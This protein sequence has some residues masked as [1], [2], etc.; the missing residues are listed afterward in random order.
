LFTFCH[1]ALA[2]PY[3][4]PFDTL[5]TPDCVMLGSLRGLYLS[6]G[7][8]Y[9]NDTGKYFDENG[10][11]AYWSQYRWRYYLVPIEMGYKT[12]FG[13][14]FGTQI[15]VVD[16]RTD[17]GWNSGLGDVW[18][19]T[20]YSFKPNEWLRV[21]GRLA[22][23]F[24]SSH[25]GE[26]PA[27]TDPASAFDLC[28]T[29]DTEPTDFLIVE[30][31]LGYRFVGRTDAGYDQYWTTTGGSFYYMSAY[32]GFP[33]S[34]RKII[35]TVPFIVDLSTTKYTSYY[36]SHTRTVSFG[37]NTGIKST[38]TVGKTGLSAITFSCEF[39]IAGQNIPRN[40]Y[41]GTMFATYFP[42]LQII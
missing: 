33:F 29:A 23:K 10:E 2:L 42:S 3:F 4:F 34:D 39:P 35:F 7:F 18:L 13:L 15:S 5:N 17:V 19:K 12:R 31:N 36:G 27:I 6:G 38:I 9:L 24:A 30:C 26:Q 22:G 8:Y 25:G 21:A 11:S 14:Y 41:V 37:F 1:P 16:A 20:K 40:Y 32:F 28:L